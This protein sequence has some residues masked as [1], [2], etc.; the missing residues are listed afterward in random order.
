MGCNCNK[1][2]NNCGCSKTSVQY[3][4][5]TQ[6]TSEDCGCPVSDLSTDCIVYQGE[7]SDCTGVKKGDILTSALQKMNEYI[8]A[9]KSEFEN[10]FPIINIGTGTGSIFKGINLLGKREMRT[11]VSSDNSVEITTGTN[12]VD[13]KIQPQCQPRSYKIPLPD[14]LTEGD[15]NVYVIRDMAVPNEEGGE[16]ESFIEKIPGKDDWG[17]KLKYYDACGGN[18]VPIQVTYGNSYNAH[19]NIHRLG[20]KKG[21]YTLGNPIS[22]LSI[23]QSSLISNELSPDT[24]G[25]F[26]LETGLTNRP[27]SALIDSNDNLIL[28]G[29][30]GMTYRELEEPILT[31]YDFPLIMVDSSGRQVDLLLNSMP[32]IDE[33]N[34]IKFDENGNDIIAAYSD[35]TL[36]KGLLK[37]DRVT[38]SVDDLY[39]TL[40]NTFNSGTPL[41]LSKR[42]TGFT[43]KPDGT[44]IA[45]G[46]DT[47]FVISSSG[48]VLQ[49]IPYQ[50]FSGG[51]V[52]GGNVSCELEYIPSVNKIVF[53]KTG[54]TNYSETYLAFA[55][56]GTTYTLDATYTSN[57]GA[58]SSEAF[59][60]ILKYS[61]D[62]VALVQ[63]GKIVKI[64]TDGTV[65]NTFSFTGQN[66]F[67]AG[68][69]ST[70]RIILFHGDPVSYLRRLNL[71]GTEDTGLNYAISAPDGAI[72]YMKGGTIDSQNRVYFYGDFYQNT[73][74]YEP[75]FKSMAFRRLFRATE[76]LENDT[77]ITSEFIVKNEFCGY[78]SETTAWLDTDGTYLYLRVADTEQELPLHVTYDISIVEAVGSDF[79]TVSS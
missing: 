47:V 2:K 34:L 1:T 20:F 52:T 61:N 62:K 75:S 66:I 43:V 30:K 76:D 68:L 31:S 63:N 11:L 50:N 4:I 29:F 72:G 67:T 54:G 45:H 18:L 79:V 46:E 36:G 23:I 38:Q 10:R 56:D 59:N 21:V 41:N 24:T 58:L 16:N 64:N 71:D 39:W 73:S 17:V 28:S 22:N 12:E 55:I 8:C 9:I 37:I 70:E 49:T 60:K 53:I 14:Y 57:L 6:P 65:D 42:I 32:S 26:Y 13:L 5:C 77:I 51:T 19:I 69:D 74:V 25:T 78:P 3:N 33:I 44:I 7:D 48:T 35:T 15:S 27:Q 40:K